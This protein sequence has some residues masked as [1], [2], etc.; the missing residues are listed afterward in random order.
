MRKIL[1]L[2]FDGVLHGSSDFSNFGK[3]PALCRVLDQMPDVDIVISSTWRETY[4]LDL[5]KEYFPER[6]RSR[7]IGGTPMLTEG[8]EQGSRQREIEDYLALQGLHTGNAAWVAL[9]DIAAFF[10]GNCPFLIL[11]DGRIGFQ[12]ENGEHLLAWYR[13]LHPQ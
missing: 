3:L 2:D 9:D 12:E 7:V 6:I 10:D 5:L 1:F 8:Y 4:P 13:A 11:T